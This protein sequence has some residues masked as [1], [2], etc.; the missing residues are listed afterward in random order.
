MWRTP[1]SFWAQIG[2]L[3][4]ILAP[5]TAQS[6]CGASSLLLF[7]RPR[8][9]LGPNWPRRQ[10]GCRFPQLPQV[11]PPPAAAVGVSAERWLQPADGA[12]QG[13]TTPSSCWQLAGVQP[14]AIGRAPHAHYPVHWPHLPSPN[15][16]GAGEAARLAGAAG[17]PAGSPP[18]RDRCWPWPN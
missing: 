2:P 11:L 7:R 5:R 14:G 17:A 16:C 1:G 15:G 13:L 9:S 18:T 12:G 4:Y 3:S 6:Y 8:L 10:V